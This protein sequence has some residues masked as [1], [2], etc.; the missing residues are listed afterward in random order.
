MRGR[1]TSVSSLKVGR[2]S[3]LR[4]CPRPLRRFYGSLLLIVKMWSWRGSVSARG[5]GWPTCGS[6]KALPSSWALPSLGQRFR[7]VKPRTIKL[8][9]IRVP[10]YYAAGCCPKPLSTRPRWG[11]RGTS[12]GGGV[13]WCASAPH[14]W[15]PFSEYQQSVQPARDG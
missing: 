13:L 7:G 14:S 15:P 3:S 1:W 2:S 12:S 9:R 11:R 6:R 8:L 4:I 10:C 5:M